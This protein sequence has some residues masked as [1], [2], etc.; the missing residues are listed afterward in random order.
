MTGFTHFTLLFQFALL[1][2]IPGACVVFLVA[3]L[4]I[5]RFTPP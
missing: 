1:L 2:V 3:L 5:R 4:G